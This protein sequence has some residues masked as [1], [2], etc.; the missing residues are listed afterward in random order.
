MENESI[1]GVRIILIHK[2]K[3]L[4]QL[5]DNKPDISHPNKW[6][7]VSGGVEKGEPLE[8]AIRRECKEEVGIVPK[9]IIYLGSSEISAC[10]Y[11]H[12]TDAEAESLVL[13]EG[14]EIRWFDP[15]K[16]T[17]LSMTPKLQELVTVYLDSLK[18]VI[19]GG[20]LS[21]GDFGLK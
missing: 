18:E 19:A 9:N 3:C 15:T 2:G 1:N 12:L 11:A 7:F 8:K 17:N 21:A 13:G 10:F 5:R 14:Q 6:S 4:F 20:T 16:M